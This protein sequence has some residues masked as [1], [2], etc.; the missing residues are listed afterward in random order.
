MNGE[1]N[2]QTYQQL[3]ITIGRGLDVGVLRAGKPN[4][5]NLGI[6]PSWAQN[7]LAAKGQ[8]YIVADGMGGAS[9]GQQASQIA[10]NTTLQ[11]YYQDPDTDIGRSLM[12]AIQ[13]ANAEIYRLG[14]SNPD[15]QG[16]GT[17][18]V[19]AVVRGNE[20]VVA[21][22]GDSRAY[23]LRG[24]ALQQLT[25]DHSWVQE[26][27]DSGL[28]TPE[29]AARHEQ[30]NVITRNLGNEPQVHPDVATFAL[31]EG[32]ALLLCSDGLWGPVSDEEIAAVLQRQ[33]GD[34]AAQSLIALANEHG[35]PDNISTVTL[36]LGEHV[37]PSMPATAAVR[38]KKSNLSMA[39]IVGIML[40]TVA[41]VAFVVFIF[42]RGGPK[43]S[44]ATGSTAIPKAEEVAAQTS[45]TP[46]TPAPGTTTK[47]MTT[48]A[49]ASQGES[50]SGVLPTS[51]AAPTAMPVT[52]TPGAPAPASVSLPVLQPP[53][54]LYA[55]PVLLA[56]KEG[57]RLSSKGK[58]TFQWE[59]SG[60][61]GKDE[62][63][64]VRVWK[65]GE[66]HN[67]VG[68]AEE[69]SLRYNP[70]GNGDYYWSVAI[71]SGKDNKVRD[72]LSP[73]AAPRIFKVSEGDTKS[74]PKPKKPPKPKK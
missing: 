27:V 16:M 26:Q 30:R 33:S 56:P 42:G 5:D 44:Q 36:H 20:L 17:T 47:P 10:V 58:I 46:S 61:L 54:T 71:I 19:A 2:Q 6:P 35:G 53:P 21:H 38:Q 7:Q 52:P 24:G 60:T 13:T 57:A 32:D 72:E 34:L 3:K 31:Q 25:K 11:T 68:W 9:G 65:E 29:Q 39:V 1:M 51:T 48:T 73:E 18:I 28:L 12:R 45:G 14:S 70:K 59:W 8:L 40:G 55:A 49:P 43:N 15:L 50:Q 37:P 23:L 22:V 64:D 67:G 69:K 74:K 41:A 63:F 4:Q 62:H 66:P